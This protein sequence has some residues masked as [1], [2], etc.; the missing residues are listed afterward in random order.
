MPKFQLQYRIDDEVVEATDWQEQSDL[1]AAHAWALDWASDLL[2]DAVEAGD[3]PHAPRAV[4][5]AGEEG[6]IL[7]YVVFWGSLLAP[8]ARS[9]ATVH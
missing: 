8:A 3:S 1:D 5:I 6:E 9:G 2:A 4:E 7:L